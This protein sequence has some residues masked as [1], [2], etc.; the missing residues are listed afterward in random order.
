MKVWGLLF[1]MAGALPSAAETFQLDPVHSSIEFRIAHHVVG[2]VR[3]RFDK[4]SGSFDYIPGKP[5]LWK[6]SATI[7]AA[8][9]NTGNETR[10]ED[11]RSAK[12]F[13]VKRCPTLQFVSDNASDVAGDKSKLH[14]RLTIHCVTRPVILDV[15]FGGTLNN[16]EGKLSAGASA[17]TKIN[18]KDFG[19]TF[20]KKL[21]AG[22]LMVGEEVEIYLE[23]EAAEKKP[24]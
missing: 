5:E 12:F 22:G 7:D 15:E 18:R 21:D 6:A 1:I 10:D 24:G 19:M 16:P 9:I 13:D 2:K 14:G 8:S 20:S 23:L 11:L 17:T 4:F 3:G